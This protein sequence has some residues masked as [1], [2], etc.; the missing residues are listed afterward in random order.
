M[1]DSNVSE[2]KEEDRQLKYKRKEEIR[3]MEKKQKEH[4]AE[5][6]LQKR[7]SFR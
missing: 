5:Y 2:M 1:I 3:E 4:V 6:F 7:S